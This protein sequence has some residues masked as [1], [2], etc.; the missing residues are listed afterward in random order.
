MKKAF[1]I[2]LS[3]LSISCNQDPKQEITPDYVMSKF[4]EK[5]R[6]IRKLEYQAQRIDTFTSGAV[7]NNH[8]YALIEKDK[9]DT[10]F[11]F[12]FYA[13]R[14][15]IPKEY[16]YDQGRAFDISQE[17]KN[18][19]TEKGHYGHLGSPGGQMVHQSLFKLDSVYKKVS[20]EE[21]PET[22]ILHFEFEDDSTYNVSKNFKTL[23]LNKESFLPVRFSQTSTRAGE[24]YAGHLILSDIQT[25]EQVENSIADQKSQILNYAV[26]QPK[27]RSENRLLNK[28]LPQKT[29]PNLLD[30][31]EMVSL[32][33]EKLLLIDF[34]EYWCGPCLASFPKVE[35][36]KERYSEDLEVIGIVSDRPEKARIIVEQKAT[37]FVNAVGDDALKE[38]F[39]I[40]SYP[41]YFLIDKNGVVKKEY[42]GFSEDIEEDI[43]DLIK[44]E[45]R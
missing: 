23:E 41:R 15:D 17:N 16:I 24:R 43:K 18:Y 3:V 30:G 34:W 31:E 37:S 14:N 42:F 35:D 6:E 44:D 4:K 8:G 10:V 36:L 12:S 19:E 27:E 40:N 26:V 1:L 39:G 2:L 32:N 21:T 22:Y 9:N 7:W 13:K 11:G 20:I 28:K 5:S 33:K 45:D 38:E 25:N 29:L